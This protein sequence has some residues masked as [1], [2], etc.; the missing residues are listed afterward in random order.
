MQRSW[1]GA[2]DTIGAGVT[3]GVTAGVVM[4]AGRET[5]PTAERDHGDRGESGR[6]T[7]R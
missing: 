7:A 4:T 1:D 6:E 5:L 2:I 3:A